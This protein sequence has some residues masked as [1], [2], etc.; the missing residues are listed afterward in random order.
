MK[1][2]ILILCFNE[3]VE[4]A[5]T[6][7][8]AKLINADKEIIIIDNFSTDGTREI[9]KTFQQDSSL[10]I[11]LHDKNMGV[12]FSVCEGIR[13]AQG[14]Y[15]YSPGAD[16]EYRMEDVY[17]MIE[18]IEVEKLDGVFGSRLLDRKGESRFKLIKERPYWLGS[19]I[20]TALINLFYGRKFTD[21]IATKLLK[22]GIL[23]ELGC[24]VRS[25]AFEFEL[26][27]RLCK[28]GYR[29]EE[30]PVYYKPRTHREGKTIRALDMLP[31]LW[32]IFRIK[33]LARV[34]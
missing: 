18:K 7:Q 14:D 17:K 20:G 21:I 34:R 33:F 11:I 13:L 26:V 12:G 1:L 9:L 5:K 15:L 27:S 16:Q 32:A 30:V 6:I 3:K 28:Q 4:I 29:I 31:A 19:I 24:Q 8:Q 25:Q 2:T 22:T 23:K 10:K